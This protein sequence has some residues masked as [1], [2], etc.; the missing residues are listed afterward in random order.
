M[1][2]VG[3]K[4]SVTGARTTPGSSSEV[5]HIMLMPRGQ[6]SAPLTR[7]GR[8]PCETAM[9][10]YLRYQAMRTTSQLPLV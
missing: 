2:T 7:A 5:F 1:L 10:E 3:P 8:W 6:F 4:A 9:A